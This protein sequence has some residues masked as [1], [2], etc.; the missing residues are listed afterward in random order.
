MMA[1]KTKNDKLS[2]LGS[3]SREQTAS[4]ANPRTGE[5]LLVDDLLRSLLAALLRWPIELQDLEPQPLEPDGFQKL[6]P[7]DAYRVVLRASFVSLAARSRH[8]RGRRAGT[9][10]IS[11]TVGSQRYWKAAKQ[12]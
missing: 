11:M 3:R 4:H 10:S 12:A 7:L 1:I 6:R 5:D 9:A 8:F 2:T